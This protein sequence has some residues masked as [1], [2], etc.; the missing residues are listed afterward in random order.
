[1]A[2]NEDL[3]IDSVRISELPTT[4]TVDKDNDYIPLARADSM[5]ISGGV[6]YKV[7]PQQLLDGVGLT[8]EA[9]DH[10]DITGNVISATY[11]AATTSDPGLMSATDKTKLNGIEASANNYTL[12]VAT[13]EVLGG[14]KAGT[15]VTIANDG[16][17]SASQ[18]EYQ[19]G[20]NIQISAQYEISATDTTYSDATQSASGLMSASDKTKLDGIATNANNYTLPAATDSAIGGVKQGTNVTIA[21]DGTISATNTTYSTATTSADGLMSS[22]DKSKLDNIEANANNYSLPIATSAVLGGVK[23]GNNITIDA[24]GTINA[25]GGGG[26]SS[27]LSGLT[28]VTLTTP[29][30]GQALVYD[31][32]KWVNG[33]GG[34][35]AATLAGLTDVTISSSV[36]GGQVLAYDGTSSW[37][38]SAAP[39]V[40]NL[41][42]VT[43]SSVSN[44]QILRYNGSKW[45]NSNE[46]TPSTPALGNLTNVTLTSP[47]AGDALIYDNNSS[48]WVNG[49]VAY[50]SLSGKPTIPDGL[51]DLTDDVN[52][53]SPSA[54]EVLTYDGTTNKWINK[55]SESASVRENIRQAL[56]ACFAHVAWSNGQGQ[57]FYDALAAALYEQEVVSISAVFNQGSATI[58]TTDSLDVLRQYLVVTATY[59][60]TSTMPVTTYTLSGTLTAGTSTITATYNGVT[61][62]FTVTVTAAT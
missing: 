45:V 61:T 55:L 47:G 41:S 53:T 8:Y 34:G 58:Y 35:G 44:N 17:L 25:T 12:P 37:V 16:T 22:T 62:T 19:A 1:M 54:D 51:A 21:A 4:S 5:S 23:Q 14:V 36:A 7:T 57:G 52:I 11:S 49:S 38:N 27:S 33:N 18:I 30:S 15:N 10:I 39:A 59:E 24:D 2:D 9:G 32:T 42:D 48:E 28:D 13:N 56:L 3:T 31:G 43:L 29:T 60:D 20:S 40:S 46:T 26:G 50:S 6:T